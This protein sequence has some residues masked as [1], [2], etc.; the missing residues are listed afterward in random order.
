MDLKFSH[1]LET[2]LKKLVDQ[3]ITIR[4]I[5]D[6]T[7]EKG[8]MLLAGLFAFPFLLP[9]PPG[10][11]SIL[12]GSCF[13]LSL[14]LA[15]GRKELWLPKKL[16]NF[17]FPDKIIYP[18]LRFIKKLS[19]W[20]EKITAPRLKVIAKNPYIWR[21]NGLCIAWLAILLML[22]IPLTNPLPTIGIVLLVIA[23]IESDGLLMCVAYLW[24]IIVSLL[25]ILM[26]SV[27][28]RMAEQLIQQFFG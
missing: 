12:G 5:L 26:P 25:F 3:P 2:L 10:V 11:S 27:L 7:S 14:Q 8:L 22:P 28:V 17:R 23:T 20:F 4:E 15:L 18:L 24:S 19:N 21:I 1:E 16:A 9:M 13:L 6:G